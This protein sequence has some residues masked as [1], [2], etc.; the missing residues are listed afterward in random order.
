MS[1]DCNKYQCKTCVYFTHIGYT[2]NTCSSC[3]N[4]SNYKRI[5]SRELYIGP[6][7]QEK[8]MLTFKNGGYIGY[9]RIGISL[10]P[11]IV[12][13]I[14]NDPATIVFWADGTKTVVKTQHGETFDPEKGLAMAISKKAMGNKGGYYNEFK[15]WVDK[16][17]IDIFDEL[18]ST[19]KTLVEHWN[20]LADS[21][22]KIAENIIKEGD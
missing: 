4:H 8:P 11:A 10:I 7:S 12:N 17:Y 5:A 1:K 14:F 21:L 2:V 18:A 13:V 3:I 15:R 19:E 22:N 9:G 6:S 20:K 16:Y